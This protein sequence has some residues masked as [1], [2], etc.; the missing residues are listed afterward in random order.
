MYTVHLL[1]AGAVND[2]RF[3]FC[4]DEKN[5]FYRDTRKKKKIF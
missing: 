5:S 4:I 2:A 1:Y 3:Y